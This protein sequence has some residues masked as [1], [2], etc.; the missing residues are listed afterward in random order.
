MADSSSKPRQRRK[1]YLFAVLLIVFSAFT[2][3]VLDLREDLGILPCPGSS[4]DN[5]VT[6]G[7]VSD[8][9][10]G[11]ELLPM[12]RAVHQHASL[13]ISFLPLLP[14]GLRAPPVFS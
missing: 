3:D 14:Y 12:L 11:R 7:M 5:N 13:K 2:A 4:L 1:A 8:A 10:S 6:T 9:A